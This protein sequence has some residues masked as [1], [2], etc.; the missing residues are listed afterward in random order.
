MYYDRELKLYED[1]DGY[2]T[3]QLVPDQSSG[4]KIYKIHRLS[5]R[6]NVARAMG[7]P[8]QVSV[9]GTEESKRFNCIN[10]VNNAKLIS[11]NSL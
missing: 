2:S 8:V 5:S 4:R 7:R 11:K 3:V 1:D 10:A 9:F 6:E